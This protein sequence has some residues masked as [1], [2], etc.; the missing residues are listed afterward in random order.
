MKPRTE[1]KES[2]FRVT[3]SEEF[4]RTR[5]I[6]PGKKARGR[7]AIKR[8]GGTFGKKGRGETASWVVL[9]NLLPGKTKQT[10]KNIALRSDTQSRMRRG[11]GRTKEDSDH[12]PLQGEGTRV[13][14]SVSKK[15][16]GHFERLG[17]GKLGRIGQGLT[18]AIRER[19]R[20][21]GNSSRATR[22]KK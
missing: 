11:K 19:K 20:G 7:S 12:T 9:V 14:N 17:G 15:K 3:K 18:S 10:G 6:R 4:L 1:R 13:E 16:K 22:K 2:C 5:K 8:G 21:G